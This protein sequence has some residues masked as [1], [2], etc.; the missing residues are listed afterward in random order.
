M[1]PMTER[2]EPP[3]PTWA[4]ASFAVLLA[5]S[6]VAC[7]GGGAADENED[8]NRAGEDL[9]ETDGGGATSAASEGTGGGA[10]ATDDDVAGAN[11]APPDG[12]SVV[13]ERN[14][15]VDKEA[16]GAYPAARY[17]EPGLIPP[18]EQRPGDPV[19][20]RR[21]LV[22][23]GY[24]ECGLPRGAYEELTTGVDAADAAGSRGRGRGAA[25]LHER[26]DRRER[27][28]ARREQ[29]SDLSRRAPL[30]GELVVGLG[31][32]FLDFTEDPSIAVERAG[33]L[34]RG[35]E[36]SAAWER[37]ADR[38]GAIAP[39]MTMPT[40]GTNPANNLTFALIARRDA[41]TNAWLEEPALPLPPTEPP[42]VS[43]PPWWRMA[44]KHAMFN[45]GEGRR[46]HAR[47]MMSA[48][49]LCTDTIEELEAID[50]YAPDIR[51]Y[52]AS[53]EPP[54]WPFALDAALATSGR[55]VFEANCS[56]C[57][58]RY[59]VDGEGR[60]DRA[61]DR[62]PNRLV[63]LE[64]VG[65]DPA[66]AE[67]AHG[68]AGAAYI[69]W[70]NRSYYGRE[71]TAAPGPGYVAPPLDGIWATAPF[72]HNGS[73]PSVRMVLDSGTRPTRW[74]HLAADASE[75][76]SYDPEDL[77]WRHVA[78]EAVVTE[79]EGAVAPER[80]YDTDARGALERGASLRRPPE[81][82]R[83]RRRHRVPQDA[84]GR[85]LESGG[86]RAPRVPEPPGLACSHVATHPLPPLPR[87]RLRPV[88][89]QGRLRHPRLAPGARARAAQARGLRGGPRHR[90]PDARGGLGAGRAHARHRRGQS[91]R[92]GLAGLARGAGGGAR[93]RLRHRLRPARSARQPAAPA[94]ARR[95]A[96]PL[97]GRRARAGRRLPDRE[98]ASDAAVGAASRSVPT[99]RWARC[100]PPSRWRGRCAIAASPRA[101]AR[102]ARPAS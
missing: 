35:A 43:V 46:D 98:P 36:E 17:T 65:T 63:P 90:G 92:D 29:L 68:E 52:I 54:P 51:A 99:A 75:R 12:A 5:L 26:H 19:E 32:E 88:R 34:V 50:A 8:V 22:E 39:Y 55:E 20:G 58:G 71:S 61:G 18:S 38:V 84:V 24:V 2:R 41:E 40:V 87:G 3:R 89:G 14:A 79:G 1:Q 37:Y 86:R 91:R 6:L 49:M 82:R 57:H 69:D 48:S 74:H 10:A 67:G 4:K 102:P 95:R 23:E 21:A 16:L 44:K 27:R 72:L 76:E 70:F 93:D 11:A 101:S 60:R 45:L 42:P 33:A 77:G 64:L 9:A 97:A 47:L 7:G 13:A 28:R 15:F 31:N 25:L 78:D 66:L 56:V 94:R 100:T 62:Y 73:V 59:A 80:V 30:F 85:R 96:G 53:L 81:R 83:A